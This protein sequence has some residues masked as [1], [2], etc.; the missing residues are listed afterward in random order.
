MKP[1]LSLSNHVIGLLVIFDVTEDN[2][3]SNVFGSLTVSLLF[4]AMETFTQCSV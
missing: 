1:V 4:I 3:C 2:C